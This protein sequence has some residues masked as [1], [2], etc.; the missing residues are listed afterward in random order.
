[1]RNSTAAP[2][3]RDV[4]NDL[5]KKMKAADRGPWQI[6]PTREEPYDRSVAAK[7]QTV[8]WWLGDSFQNRLNKSLLI[9]PIRIFCIPT[10]SQMTCCKDL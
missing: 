5:A 1:M 2:G 3:E 4:S 10:V 9:F 6:V 8:L 7:P